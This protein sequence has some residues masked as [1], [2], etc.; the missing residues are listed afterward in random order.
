MEFSWSGKVDGQVG[1]GKVFHPLGAETDDGS[2]TYIDG[3]G[4]TTTGAIAHL[5]VTSV[6]AGD[7]IDV[8]FE[9]SANHVDW[10]P[11]ADGAFATADA[12]GAERLV[13][14]GTIRQYVRAVWDVTGADVS[15]EFAVALART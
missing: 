5:H 7:E 15:I 14:P 3:G 11:I 2:G 4:A 1:F 9:D 6:S 10:L 13:I 8:S 12:V